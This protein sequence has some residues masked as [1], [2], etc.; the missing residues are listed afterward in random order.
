LH[1]VAPCNSDKE[2]IRFV[3]HAKVNSIVY[4]R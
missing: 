2:I 4:S 3:L 1:K